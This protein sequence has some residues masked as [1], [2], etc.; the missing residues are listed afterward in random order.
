LPW[1]ETAACLFGRAVEKMANDDYLWDRSGKPDPEIVRLEEMLGAFR[2]P[3]KPSPRFVMPRPRRMRAKWAFAFAAVAVLAVGTAIVMRNLVDAKRA[4]SWHL[5]LAGGQPSAIRVGQTID[6]RTSQATIESEFVGQVRVEPGS[7]L[8]IVSAREREQRFALEHGTIHALI[9]APPARFVVD[10]PSAKAVDLGCKYTLR[11]AKDGSGLLNVETGWVAFQ[12]RQL[13]SFIPAGA[14]CTTRP[15]HGPGVPYFTD[16]SMAFIASLNSFE[17]TRV[18]DALGTVLVFARP[19]DALTLWHL[20]S[21]T[22]GGQRAE[23]FDRLSALVALPPVVGR[24]AVL[25]GDQNAMDTI[26]DALNL[27]DT[28]WWREWK[29][30]W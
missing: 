21:R 29:R 12:W 1:H 13:E 8:R 10:I 24:D 22:E 7:R 19:R 25:R 3:A 23:V 18:P 5:V 14:A 6:T 30:R 17:E 28:S 15:G 11:V 9:W 2:L 20:L 16:A 4:T 26:W 27:G